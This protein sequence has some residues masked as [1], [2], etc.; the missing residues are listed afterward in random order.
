VGVYNGLKPTRQILLTNAAADGFDIEQDYARV[1][2]V[3]KTLGRGVF[4]HLKVLSKF[5]HPT[6]L[7]I[8][9]KRSAAA[10]E[11]LRKKLHELGSTLA[12]FALT[13]LNNLSA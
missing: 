12:E 1:S 3:A 11:L 10:E 2:A 5:V 4:K 8:F 6:A 9:S 13:I 7:A